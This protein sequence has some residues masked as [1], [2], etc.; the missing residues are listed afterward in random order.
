MVSEPSACFSSGNQNLFIAFIA[1]SLSRRH[2]SFS[3][4]GLHRQIASLIYSSDK[5]LEVS[6][7]VPT[8]VAAAASL[9]HPTNNTSNELQGM[10]HSYRLDGRNYPQCL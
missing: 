2:C 1:L 6:E 9:E 8:S 10:H 7:I 4:F 5:M 3:S